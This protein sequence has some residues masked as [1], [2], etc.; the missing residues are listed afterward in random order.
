VV[1]A[2]PPQADAPQPLPASDPPSIKA[3]PPGTDTPSPLPATAEPAKRPHDPAVEVLQMPPLRLRSLDPDAA[4]Q[5]EDERPNQQAEQQIQRAL[6][7]G[8][9]TETGDPILD[10]T[11]RVIRKQGSVLRDWPADQAIYS[12]DAEPP[13]GLSPAGVSPAPPSA[14][15]EAHYKTAESLLRSAR[16]LAELPGNDS[17]RQQIVAQLRAEAI[18]CL[19][20]SGL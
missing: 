17:Q 20:G 19:Q 10:E 1:S 2:E 4:P 16:L 3:N 7:T 14:I 5:A 13:A 9:A 18:R 11:L 8:E 15:S 6:Q 12:S